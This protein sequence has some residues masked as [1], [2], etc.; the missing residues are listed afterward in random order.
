LTVQRLTISL[1][2]SIAAAIDSHMERHGYS[3]RSEAIRDLVRDGLVRS[4]VDEFTG[5]V[6]ALSYVYK[7]D[8]REIIERLSRVKHDHHDLGISSMRTW[9]DHRHCME[10]T[11][12]HGRADA[13]RKFTDRV[14]AER[15]VRFGQINIVPIRGSGVRHAHGEGRSHSHETP[16]L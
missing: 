13:V 9:L 7:Y 10:V 14:L 2:D 16:A 15:G 6:A 3:N 5:C 8:Q 1:D 11:F 12:V 4:D